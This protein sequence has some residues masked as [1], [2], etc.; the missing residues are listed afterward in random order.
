[1]GRTDQA[2]RTLERSLEAEKQ[3]D[4]ASV[5]RELARLRP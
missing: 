2:I 5:G 4:A 3:T 1:M